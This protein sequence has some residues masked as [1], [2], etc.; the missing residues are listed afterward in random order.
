MPIL[1]LRIYLIYTYK[2]YYMGRKE[3]HHEW[4]AYRWTEGDEER[5]WKNFYFS[6]NILFN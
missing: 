4:T 5:K 3:T 2:K 1:C 6:C